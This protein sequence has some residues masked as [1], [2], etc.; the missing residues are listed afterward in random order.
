MKRRAKAFTLIELLVVIAIIAILAALILPALTRAKD[1]AARIQCLNNV[2]QIGIATHLYTEDFGVYPVAGDWPL[3]GGQLGASNSY[4]AN[5]Y[6]FN[7]RPLTRYAPS[8]NVFCCPR[9]KGD[10]LT[11]T[12]GPLFIAYGNSYVMQSGEDSFNIKYILSFINGSYGPPVRP[13]AITRTD[14]KIISGD[15][16]LHPNR[17]LGDRRTQWHNHGEKRAFNVVFADGHALYY[18]FPSTWGMA[19]QWTAGDPNYAWW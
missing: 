1:D 4:S 15:W 3:F 12:S 8:V 17:P 13:S 6:D 14:N 18:T 9:D 16:P 11:G 10:T 19:D 2:R 7:A 5:L